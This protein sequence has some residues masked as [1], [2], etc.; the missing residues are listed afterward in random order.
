MIAR[1]LVC[2]DGYKYEVY[3]CNTREAVGEETAQ[4]WESVLK[5]YPYETAVYKCYPANQPLS[6][7]ELEFHDIVTI[8]GNIR[9]NLDLG[10]L[11]ISRSTSEDAA[12][13]EHQAVIDEFKSGDILLLTKAEREAIYGPEKLL[14]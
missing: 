7:K 6:E 2:M 8:D 11:Y 12:A 14:Q 3:T 1:T 5:E 13:M 10:D 4:F 9:R